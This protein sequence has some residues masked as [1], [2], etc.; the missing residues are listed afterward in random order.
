[1]TRTGATARI[2]A[3]SSASLRNDNQK[4]T[5]KNT[6]ILRFAQMG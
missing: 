6:E 2:P 5:R 4:D 1:M 3:D